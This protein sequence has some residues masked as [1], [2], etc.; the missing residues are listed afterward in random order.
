MAKNDLLDVGGRKKTVG[1]KLTDIIKSKLWLV[2]FISLVCVPLSHIICLIIS[3]SISSLIFTG[4][5]VAFSTVSAVAVIKIYT[6]KGMVYE[7]LKK[8]R[9]YFSF[10]H[11]LNVIES[12]MYFLIAFT[13]S[14]FLLI[15]GSE[16]FKNADATVEEAGHDVPELLHAIGAAWDDIGSFLIA[17]IIAIMA[18]LVFGCIMMS[19]MHMSTNK[20]LTE[21]SDKMGSVNALN[22]KPP[23]KRLFFFGGVNVI[24]GIGGII[25]S[26]V[27]HI[28]TVFLGAFFIIQGLVF[29]KINSRLNK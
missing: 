21:L 23:I 18:A 8:M 16:F 25:L 5:T 13:V 24:I 28:T 9:S 22:A 19:F 20:Y 17:V 1:S 12:I 14:T 7:N 6:G 3:C 26:S 15:A 11:I 29:K 10:L 27:T 2:Y 4:F